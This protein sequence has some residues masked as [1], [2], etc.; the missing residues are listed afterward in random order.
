MVSTSATQQDL[1]YAAM[2]AH[3]TLNNLRWLNPYNSNGNRSARAPRFSFTLRPDKTT[4]ETITGP[5]GGKRFGNYQWQRTST[6]YNSNDRRVFA[7]CWHGHRAFLEYLFNV[8][9]NAIVR[10]SLGGRKIVHRGTVDLETAWI[11]LGA[12]VMGG[13]PRAAEACVCPYTGTEWF[14]GLNV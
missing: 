7:V 8:A 5:R 3:V 4:R 14:G 6:G 12:P 10:S 1:E 13:Y 2:R 11:P 9:P